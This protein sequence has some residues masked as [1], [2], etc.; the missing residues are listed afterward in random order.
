MLTA[1]TLGAGARVE[2]R[3]PD[4]ETEGRGDCRARRA[5]HE[6]GTPHDGHRKRSQLVPDVR[7]WRRF[8]DRRRAAVGQRPRHRTRFGPGGRGSRRGPESRREQ[9]EPVRSAKLPHGAS[10]GDGHRRAAHQQRPCGASSSS[11]R[12]SASCRSRS[13]SCRRSSPTTRRVRPSRA[14]SASTRSS[15]CRRASAKFRSNAVRRSGRHAAARD[16]RRSRALGRDRTSFATPLQYLKGVGPRRAADF[17]HA[18]LHTV[19]DLLYRFPIRYEDRSHLQPIASLKPGRAASIA[20]RILSC[21]LR[22]TRRPGFKIF[23]ALIAD[24]SGPM[25]AVWLNQPFL[26]DV[27]VAGQHVVFYGVVDARAGAGLQLTNPQYEILEDEEGETIHTGRIVPVYEKTG[28]VTPKIQR[29]LVFDV[30]QRLPAEVPDHLPEELRLRLQLPARHA[31]LLA[32][33]F[34]PAGRVDRGAQSF[35]DAGPAPPDLRGSVSLSDGRAGAPTC[36]RGGTQAGDDSRGRPHPRIGPARAAVPADER[37][38]AGPEGNRR[39]SAAPAADEPAAAGGRRG[40]ED[41]RRA[42]RGARRHGER[43]AG[44]V[45]GADGDSGRAALPQHL[46]PASAVAL[47]RRPAD[48]RDAGGRQKAA[49]RRGRSRQRQSRRRDACARAGR[50]ALSPARPRRHRRAASVRRAAAGDASRQ[51]AVSGR[52]RDDGDADPADAG[53]DALRRSRRVGDPRYAAGTAAD[54]DVREARIS[55]RRGVRVRSRSARR[56]AAGVCHLSAGRRVRQDRSQ[57]GHRDGGPSGAGGLSRLQGRAA[58]RA[59][60]GRTPRIA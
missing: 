59:A 13:C 54:Q 51:G 45:H 15:S 30:L 40:G 14:A 34:P 11:P 27:F 32:A 55:T 52:P 12:A 19:E 33:H 6:A 22:S 29:R 37:A 36:G 25:R 3:C 10:A 18:G 48:R 57:G 39:R 47:S 2:A 17:E 7:A 42:A 26:R 49:A 28:S 50:C 4:D 16:H 9:H 60:E 43:A 1:S 58:P 20:A 44:R 56:R 38:E 21:G 23:E 53:A 31:A 35:C 24:E 8:A 46:A 5:A 41:D